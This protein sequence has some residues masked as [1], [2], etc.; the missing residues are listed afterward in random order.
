MCSPSWL[1]QFIVRRWIDPLKDERLGPL[2]IYGRRRH[3]QKGLI[4]SMAAL[5]RILPAGRANLLTRPGRSLEFSY[6]H[7]IWPGPVS[8]RTSETNGMNHGMA[9][10]LAPT[11]RKSSDALD[12][13]FALGGAC[14]WA[15]TAENNLGMEI[16]PLTRPRLG[17]DQLVSVNRL[18]RA[19]GRIAAAWGIPSHCLL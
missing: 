13:I 5:R 1:G 8:A 12:R 7:K 16:W 15:P 11:W 9:L 17:S 3:L 14:H 2:P 6:R 4:G 19:P 18:L 10:L